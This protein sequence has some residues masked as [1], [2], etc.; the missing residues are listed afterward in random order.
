MSTLPT[1]QTAITYLRAHGYKVTRSAAGYWVIGPAC[2]G[3]FTTAELVAIGT[4]L[5]HRSSP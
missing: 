1:L 4:K 2:K 3:H 5:Q